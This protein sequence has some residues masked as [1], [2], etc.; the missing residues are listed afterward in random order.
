MCLWVEAATKVVYVQNRLP[1]SALGL[2][3]PEEMFIGKKLEVSHLEIFGYLVFIRIPKE[4][5]NKLEPLRKE[6][7]ICGIL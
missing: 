1:H 2:K 5:R 7:N 4:K 3:T 6:G